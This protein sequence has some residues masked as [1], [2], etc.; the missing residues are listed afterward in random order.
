MTDPAFDAILRN[1]SAVQIAGEDCN[2]ICVLGQIEHDRLGRF[3][4]G[5]WILTSEILTPASQ[6]VP[7]NIIRSLNTRYLLAGAVH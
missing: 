3:A 7:G 6:I 2:A 5:R 1:W 4:D